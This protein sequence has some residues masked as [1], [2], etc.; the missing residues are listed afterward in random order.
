MRGC[1]S[2]TLTVVVGVLVR[3]N[4]LVDGR[5]GEG[6]LVKSEIGDW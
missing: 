2:V 6:V 4:L 5:K 3:V 1:V